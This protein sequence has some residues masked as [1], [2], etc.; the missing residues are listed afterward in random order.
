MM[1]DP[2]PPSLLPTL[3]S[4]P[5]AWTPWTVLSKIRVPDTLLSW[6]RTQQHGTPAG[7]PFETNNESMLMIN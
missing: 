7:A 4:T 2:L 1:G 3:T 5:C 6:L